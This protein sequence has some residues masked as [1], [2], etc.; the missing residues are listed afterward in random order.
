LDIVQSVIP[1]F[2]ILAL[3]VALRRY[4]FLGESFIDAANNLVYYL[5]LPLLLFYEVGTTN[6]LNSFSGSLVIGAY[7]ASF[8][9]FLLAFALSRLLGIGPGET[10]AFVQG[11]MRANLAYMGLPVV[12]NALGQAG[13]SRAGIFLGFVV[14]VINALSVIALMVPHGAGKEEGIAATGWRILRQVASNPLIL[15]CMAGIAWSLLKLPFPLLIRRTLFLLTPATLPLALLCLGGSFSFER[16]RKGFRLAALAAF[17]K[18]IVV[19]GL[20][21]AIY[22]WMGVSGTDLRIGVIMLGC[23]T[24]V[25]T[26]I[27]ATQ[28][29]GDA[30]LAGTIVIVS[31]VASAFTMTGWLFLLR[32]MGW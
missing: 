13:L 27:L 17:L 1:V 11:S 32:A 24:G 30:D 3:G 18:V 6:F 4:R 19:T 10:G 12:F 20:A 15:G 8:A 9:V 23:P 22:R 14:P 5:L 21:L 16:A 29:Q 2:L 25:I 7:A 31:T 28:L 26:Y